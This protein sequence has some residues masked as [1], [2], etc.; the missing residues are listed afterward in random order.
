M[1]QP[2]LDEE[3]EFDMSFDKDIDYIK[4]VYRTK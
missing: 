3:T 2:F 1:E 4:Q